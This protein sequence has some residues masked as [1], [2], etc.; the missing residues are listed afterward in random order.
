MNNQKNI[1]INY[2]S[3]LAVSLLLMASFITITSCSE[4][5]TSTNPDR[6]MTFE[7]VIQNGREFEQIPQS[8]TTDTLA[9]SEPVAEDRQ[10]DENGS[11]ESQRW[12]C[13]TKTLS[14]LDGNGQFPLFN[15]NA[16]VVYPGNL[17]QGITLSNATPSP[18]V[19]ERAG[20]TISYNLTN[21]NL[22]STFTVD[23]VSKS[24]IQNAMNNI[25]ANSGEEVPANFQLDIQEV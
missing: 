16:D 7:E 8:R 13:T 10:V 11:T 17:L 3:T 15:T 22:S 9:V 6:E 1:K 18:I 4:N 24:S 14:V 20:G 12:I 5:G 23:R 19:V 25:I 21:G 2:M